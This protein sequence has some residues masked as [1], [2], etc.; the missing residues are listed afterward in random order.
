[1][2]DLLIRLGL[3]IKFHVPN[4]IQQFSACEVRRL[5]QLNSKDLSRLNATSAASSTRPVKYW[6]SSTVAYTSNFTC[7]ELNA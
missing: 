7:T 5:N 1:M 4:L 3:N 2:K 6:T